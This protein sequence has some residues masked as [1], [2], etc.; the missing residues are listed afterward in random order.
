MATLEQ[1][2]RSLMS[3]ERRLDRHGL[4]LYGDED[5][6]KGIVKR[7]ENQRRALNR[8]IW[9]LLLLGVTVWIFTVTLL[10]GLIILI[11]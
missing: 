3:M 10:I 9:A 4:I 8:L 2:E 1:L 6:T 5:I 7:L 11:Q